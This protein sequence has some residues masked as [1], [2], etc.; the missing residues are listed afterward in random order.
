MNYETKILADSLLRIEKK[1]D[2]LLKLAVGANK[3]EPGRLP[4]LLQPLTAAK[5]ICPMCQRVIEYQVVE[6]ANRHPD[7]FIVARVCGCEPTV[8]EHP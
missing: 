1:L 5:Q 7:H 2:E 4:P 8:L 6:D 3:V